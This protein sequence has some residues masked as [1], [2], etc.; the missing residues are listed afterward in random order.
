VGRRWRRGDTCSRPIPDGLG[1]VDAKLWGDDTAKAVELV[2]FSW[3]G[4][5][6]Q[7]SLLPSRRE[8]GDAHAQ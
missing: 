6:F 1:L 7:I 5:T 8:G 3:E 4:V 2:I